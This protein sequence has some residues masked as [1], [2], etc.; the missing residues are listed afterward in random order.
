[1]SIVRV[2]PRRTR[3]TPDDALAFTGPPPGESLPDVQ[4]VH[5]SVAFTYDLDRGHQLAEAWVRTGLPVRMGGPAFHEPGGDFIPGRYLKHG[6]V[7]TSRGCPNRCWFCA[8][9]KREGGVLRE[10]PITEG[11]NVLDDNLLA[12]SEAHIRAVFAMLER[13]AKRPL[14]TGGLEARLL[15]PWH[16]DLLRSVRATRMYFAYDTPEDYEP[17]VAAGR[18]LRQGGISAA[19][20]RAACYV[21]IGYPGDTMEAAERRLADT[22][23]AGFLPYAMLYRDNTGNTDG[24]WRKFQTSWIRPVSIVAQMRAAG[25]KLAGVDGEGDVYA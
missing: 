7:I 23:R 9:P 22:W 16:V 15:R 24:A 5:V 18:L 17:L 8:V 19:S 20:H 4:E 10:L 25:V 2:F 11:W 12:C 13:Q 14:F 1:M 6:Y 21:L 3:A